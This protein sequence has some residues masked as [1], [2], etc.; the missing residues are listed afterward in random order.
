MVMKRLLVLVGTL[1]V[2]SSATAGCS[3]VEKTL[4]LLIGSEEKKV[5]EVTLEPVDKSNS[6]SEVNSGQDAKLNK[7]GSVPGKVG[8]QPLA[9]A[10][11]L[12][13]L[14]GFEKTEVVLYFGSK[15]G[16]YLVGETREIAKVQGI[17]RATIQELING[18]APESGLAQTIPNGVKLLDINIKPDGVAVVSFNEAIKT[19]HW[20]GTAGEQLTV[21]SIV[22][23]LTQ[24]PAIQKVQFLIEDQAVET[25]AGHL[26]ISQPLERNAEVIKAK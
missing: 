22:N 10:E 13:Q 4:K 5:T 17:A 19:Q 18:P 23:T 26:E 21:Y 25:L 6:T 8:E 16:T 24:F 15:D 11:G 20:G 1:A 14:V 9:K 12:K 2:L 3:P 7:L